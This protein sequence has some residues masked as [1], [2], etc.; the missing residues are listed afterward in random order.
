[1]IEEILIRSEWRHK[2]LKTTG[3]KLTSFRLRL[4]EQFI[5]ISASG[6][7]NGIMYLQ[8]H[9]TLIRQPRVIFVTQD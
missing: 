1:M 8:K 5:K 3:Q 9:P 2:T 6:L 7:I 4:F